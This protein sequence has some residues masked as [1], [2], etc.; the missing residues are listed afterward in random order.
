VSSLT[1]NHSPKLR[2]SQKRSPIVPNLLPAGWFDH[3]LAE[4]LEEEVGKFWQSWRKIWASYSTAGSPAPKRSMGVIPKGTPGRVSRTLRQRI[5]HHRCAHHRPRGRSAVLVGHPVE[6]NQETAPN[7]WRRG[8]TFGS[9]RPQRLDIEQ[10]GI[11]PCESRS[12]PQ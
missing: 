4:R 11:L 2:K 5:R 8:K 7:E 10:F 12:G 9:P 3:Q 6:G 1:A